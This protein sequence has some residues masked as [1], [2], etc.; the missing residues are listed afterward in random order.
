MAMALWCC[1][2]NMGRPVLVVH[3]THWDEMRMHTAARH[4][5]MDDQG[6]WKGNPGQAPHLV[7][8]VVHHRGKVGR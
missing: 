3:W 1:N 4:Q 5:T 7:L 8:V 2:A 6:Q